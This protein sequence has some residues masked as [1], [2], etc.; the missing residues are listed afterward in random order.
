MQDYTIRVVLIDKPNTQGKCPV[1]II[2]TIKGRR[3]HKSTG[4]RV[5]PKDWDALNLKVRRSATNHSQYNIKIQNRVNEIESDLLERDLSGEQ[6]SIHSLQK[7]KS[8][9]ITKYVAELKEDLKHKLSVGRLK[10]YSV[11]ISR[12]N[13][14]APGLTFEDVDYNFLRKYEK[15]LRES[16]IEDTT[17]NSV[18]KLFKTFF[19]NALKDGTTK[20]NPFISY[21]NPGYTNPDRTFLNADEIARIEK[22]LLM[23]MDESLMIT[24]NYFLLGCYSGLRHSDWMRFNYEGFVKGERLILRAKKNGIIVSMK[25][26]SRLKIIV[27]RLKN[28]PPSLS[29]QK[30]NDYLKS[31]GKMCK[32]K[33]QLTAH[34]ARHTFGTQCAEMGIGIEVTAELMGIDVRTCKVY[35]HLTGTKLDD[36]MAKW[37]K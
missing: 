17:L 15:H 34:V 3:T 14:F 16:G 13:K 35:Y 25:M 9:L 37:D 30:T 32:I 19:S 2:V 27:E 24:A 5:L 29:N 6:L 22:L 26:H 10:H 8:R 4:I 23:P 18:W 20:N 7:K 12:I 1:K 28:L 11:E 31:I 21:K 33:K 36:D